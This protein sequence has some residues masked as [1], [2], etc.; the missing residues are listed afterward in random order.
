MELGDLLRFSHCGRTVFTVA[1]AAPAPAGLL[2]CPE[3]GLA[4]SFSLAEAPVRVRAPVVDGHRTSC[5]FLVT[6]WHGLDGLSEET[7]CELHVGI[8][9]SQGV[10]LSYT[11]SGVQRDQNGWEQSIVV[12]LVSPGNCIPNWDTQLDHFAAMDMWTADRFEEQ[13]EFGSCCYGFALGFINQL[14]MSQGRQPITREHFTSH[15]VLPRVEAATK[16]LAVFR[17]VCRHGY[18]MA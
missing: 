1:D 4:P 10:V 17:H 9:N 8:S 12:H 2:R 14:M 13:R 18:W 11:E 6:S 15:L 5:C 16:Y 3:C 7:D